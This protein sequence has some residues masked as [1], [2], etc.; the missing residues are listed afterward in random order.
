[1]SDY[2]IGRM[3]EVLK[4]YDNSLF[5]DDDDYKVLAS[6]G[7]YDLDEDELENDC[8]KGI[9]KELQEK[10]D[11][12]FVIPELGT[13]VSHLSQIIL[14]LFDNSSNLSLIFKI[15]DLG[16]VNARTNP[17]VLAGNY[18]IT[19]D[20]TYVKNGTQLAIARTI[21]HESVHAWL[22][23]LNQGPPSD[24]KTE[25]L[26]YL[27]NNGYDYEDAQ[28]MLMSDYAP[29][30][31]SSIAAWDNHQLAGSSNID[32]FNYYNALSFSGEMLNSTAFSQLSSSEQQMVLDANKNEGNATNAS[33]N[34]AKGSKCP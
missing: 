2:F 29:A 15:D 13:E 6:Y 5:S 18:T 34:N 28:H 21:I 20:D 26:T 17:N 10:D 16:A 22:S 8:V 23:Y 31:A 33:T 25:L 11:H 27:Q 3:A 1:M 24:L 19:L 30:L 32:E 12:Y 4:D 14:D 7:V 9:I